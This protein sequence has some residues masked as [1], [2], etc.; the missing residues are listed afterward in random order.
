MKP[1]P[2]K[3]VAASS[4]DHALSL[5]AEHGDE[6]RFLAGGQSLIPAMN[7]RLARP[8]VLIDINGLAAL[9]GIDRVAD[10]EI[11]VGAVTRYRALERDGDFLKACPLIADALPH[12]AH[13]AI[14]NRGTIGGNLSHADPASELPAISVAMQAR[15]HIKSASGEREV[16]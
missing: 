2:F 6:A 15:M 3:Y 8:A 13:P 4:L 12:I 11:R 7:F 1:A 14:R 10:H 9:A 5:K 16:A